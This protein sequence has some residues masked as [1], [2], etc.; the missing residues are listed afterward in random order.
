MLTARLDALLPGIRLR[1]RLRALG[2]SSHQQIADIL[3]LDGQCRLPEWSWVSLI[4]FCHVR[5][6]FLGHL[7]AR[8]LE[9]LRMS[10]IE[11]LD[12][13][14]SLME[15]EGLNLGA[16]ELLPGEVVPA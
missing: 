16:R 11:A 5:H 10:E 3:A 15:V 14:A 13:T 1:E 4:E 7:S 6:A 9:L 2:A 8:V 12:L